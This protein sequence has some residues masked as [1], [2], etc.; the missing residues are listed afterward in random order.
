[1]WNQNACDIQ[2]WFI[3]FIFWPKSHQPR[4]RDSG[5]KYW[6]FLGT[7]HLTP[8]LVWSHAGELA[9]EKMLVMFYNWPKY[10]PLLNY[11]NLYYFTHQ[12]Q[13]YNCCVHFQD[14]TLRAIQYLSPNWTIYG[15]KKTYW[16]IDIVFIIFEPW[17]EL[18][19]ILFGASQI[20]HI[21]WELNKLNC[22]QIRGFLGHSSLQCVWIGLYK[23]YLRLYHR[24]IYF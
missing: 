20:I 1:M 24:P 8:Y 16:K 23:L 15:E 17:I 7:L 6:W 5:T 9:S 21:K 19:W 13:K 14:P 10:L 2:H 3:V 22:T 11:L 18:N 12:G 4:C